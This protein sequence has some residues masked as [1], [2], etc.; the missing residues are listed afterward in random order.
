MFQIYTV[1]VLAHF[2][3][4]PDL[5]PINDILLCNINIDIN[6]F[7]IQELMR[8]QPIQL[9]SGK[10]S[11]LFPIINPKYI[12]TH[13]YSVLVFMSCIIAITEK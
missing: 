12:S 13:N 6:I 5:G 10:E 4:L 2:T 11:Q 3:I 9:I 8:V 1:L 7:L